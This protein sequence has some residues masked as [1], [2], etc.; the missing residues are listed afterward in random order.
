MLPHVVDR[1][2]LNYVIGEMI[3]ELNASHSYIRGGDVEQPKRISVGLLGCDFELDKKKNAF[4]LKKI[5]EGAV[6]DAEVRSPLRQ[7]GLE[8]KEGEYLLAV[9]G[10][11]LD[12]SKD[13][14]A[15]FQGLAGEVVT[16]SINSTASMTGARDVIVKPVSSEFRLRNLAWIE[17]N[18][19]KVEKATNGKVGYIYVPDTSINGQNELVRQFIPQHRLDGLIIDERFNSGGQFSDRFIELMNRPLYAYAARRDHQDLTIPFLSHTGPKVMV[20]NE[21]AGSG[22]DAFPYSFR[23]AGLGPLIGKRTWGGLI[24]ISGN[25]I[26]I[27][28]GFITAPNLA[29]WHPDGYWD[30]EGYGVDPDHE[31][32]N[33]PHEMAAGK[34]PQ[35]EKAV[36]AVLDLLKKKPPKKPRRPAYPDRSDRIK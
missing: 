16:L 3:A 7:P 31:V 32:E 26:L 2:D 12:T 8:V 33:A 11:P 29:I 35:L 10:Q 9:N 23:K 1:A 13:I 4:R 20:I 22:G 6:W 24:G 14:W 15:S 18:R 25:P 27:D 21:W 36:A 30:V 17:S 28:G 5:Y 34:D 19:K